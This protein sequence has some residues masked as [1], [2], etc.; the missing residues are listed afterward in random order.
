[1]DDEDVIEYGEQIMVLISAESTHMAF[2]F[3][4]RHDMP[5]SDRV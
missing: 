3:F 1:M 2:L 5:R 4:N